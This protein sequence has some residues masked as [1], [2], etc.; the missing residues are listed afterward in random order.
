[1]KETVTKIE[2]TEN[3]FGK[4]KSVTL[5]SGSVLSVTEKNRCFNVFT[6]PGEY[7]INTRDF[8]GK[9][10]VVTAKRLGNSSAAPAQA[11]TYQQAKPVANISAQTL[12]KKLEFD[13]AR[14]KDIMIECYMGIAKDIA[15]ANKKDE[16]ITP[17]R[18]MDLVAE[19]IFAH[20]KILNGY[21][22]HIESKV[23][24]V[25]AAVGGKVVEDGIDVEYHP[26]DNLPM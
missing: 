16:E 9:M 12:D 5:A 15:I 1:M 6:V 24:E 25:A 4:K 26:E 11:S 21:N 2:L 18:I 20:N 19:L 3:Q 7:D 22:P 13:K 17:G 10:A 14:Q 8:N 23:P